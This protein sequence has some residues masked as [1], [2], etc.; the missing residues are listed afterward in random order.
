M[1][2]FSS[3]ARA[4]RSPEEEAG[5][6]ALFQR[7][8][9]GRL[10]IDAA[11]R[12]L[13]LSSG[14]L[15][16]WLRCCRRTALLAFDEELRERLIRRGAPAEALSGALFT[17]SVT[18]LA[19]ADLLQLLELSGKSGLLTVTNGGVAGQLWCSAGAIIDAE[20][21]PLSGELAVYRLLGWERGALVAELYETE[22]ERTIH[23]S[24]QQLLLEAA[25][26]K[27]ECTRLRAAL[28]DEQRVLQ[29]ASVLPAEQALEPSERALCVYFEAPRSLEEVLAHSPLGDL[30]TLLGVQRL[31]EGGLL[32]AATSPPPAPTQAL[33]RSGDTLSW[34]PRR[35]NGSRWAL[36]AVSNLLL[37]PAASWLGTKV[38]NA[39][40]PDPPPSR[41]RDEST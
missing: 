2:N 21:G 19:V 38:S 41:P 10:R 30:E 24:T 36:D 39:L 27:D 1:G 15:A 20:C 7:V 31:L 12:Q 26:R 6:A 13:G 3:E 18:D 37:I 32:V 34:R 9:A 40:T 22:R 5:K 25:R 33:V 16:D 8:L 28:G 35:A 11:R 4:L 23:C 14:A 29:L 17:G